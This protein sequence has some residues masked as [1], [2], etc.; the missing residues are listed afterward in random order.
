M[1]EPTQ[2]LRH[3][4]IGNSHT[5]A[6][7]DLQVGKDGTTETTKDV[8]GNLT[9]IENSKGLFSSH[10]CSDSLVLNKVKKDTCS[11]ASH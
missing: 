4:H 3:L 2:V 6:G 11:L 1:A 7:V 5:L 9:Q 8:N 10:A